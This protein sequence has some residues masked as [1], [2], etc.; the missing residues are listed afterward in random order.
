[1][2]KIVNCERQS[3][4]VVSD[5]GIKATVLTAHDCKPPWST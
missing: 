5:G 4:P 3:I 2:A 1:M